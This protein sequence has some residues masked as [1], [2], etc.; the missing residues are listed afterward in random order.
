ML[1]W[2]N[3]FLVTYYSK[4]I[5]FKASLIMIRKAILNLTNKQQ[6]L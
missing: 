4:A 1:F 5:M 3:V 6:E 2:D